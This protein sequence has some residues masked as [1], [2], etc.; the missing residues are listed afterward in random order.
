MNPIKELF[1][2]DPQVVFLNHG[3]FGACP[4]PVFETYQA[5]QKQLEQQPVH[6]LGREFDRL[7][8][9]ARVA[10][11]L[12]LRCDPQDLAYIP[13]ATHALNCIARSIQ[14]APGDEVLTSSHE[15]G[16]CDN[17]WQFITQKCGARYLHKQIPL[18]LLSPE[19]MIDQLWSGVNQ[20]TR[21]I[22]LSHITSPTAQL[23]PVEEVCRRAR[24]AGILSVIDGAHAPGQ[25]D[26]DLPALGADFYFGNCHK[27]ML[28]PKGAAFLHARQEVQGLVEPLVVSWGWSAD[29]NTTSGSRFIDLLQWSGTAD[30]SAALSV[31]AA[32][33]FM[34]RHDW[35]KVRLRCHVLLVKAL[36]AIKEITGLPSAYSPGRNSFP[37]LP[38]Q[39]GVAPLPGDVDLPRLKINLYEKHH[40]EIPVIVWND[41]KFLRISIQGYNDETDI[42]ALLAA[43]GEEIDSCRV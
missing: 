12:A 26:L 9:Q 14:L 10:L 42:T 2:L 40:I 22:F 1:L 8:L 11:G 33:G 13:N 6:F 34:E 37:F 19:E 36:D 25:V 23:F 21:V 31:P 41:R 27:W 32:I 5:W 39:M 16:A 29:Q 17:T 43:L 4:K 7:M 3:S 38:P 20:H 30:P 18:P 15:Y 24:Q 35:A 28:S